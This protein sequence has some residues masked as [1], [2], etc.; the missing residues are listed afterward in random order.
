M[1]HEHHVR[2]SGAKVCAVCVMVARRFRRVHIDAL[3]AV[4]F[5]HRLAGN[6]RQTCGRNEVRTISSRWSTPKQEAALRIYTHP[7]AASA[8]PRSRRADSGRNRR[9]G[10]SQSSGRC[11]D[12]SECIAHGSG[13]TAFR[14]PAR[15]DRTGSDCRPAHPLRE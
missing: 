7:T 9:S 10:I 4:R 3:G 15:S 5:H 2:K 14:R 8:G 1:H 12:W 11:R 13:R 6:V